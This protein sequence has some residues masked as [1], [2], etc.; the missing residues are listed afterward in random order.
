[1]NRRTFLRGIGL[2]GIVTVGLP[3]L[4]AMF[5]GNGAALKSTKK[6]VEPRFV[7]WFNGN[8]IP[9]KYW[10]PKETGEAFEFT[11]CLNPLA[12]FR[13]D[14]HVITGLDSAAARL[15]G[16]QRLDFSPDPL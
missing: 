4:E 12:P 14:I 3:P 6:A 7:F 11:P 1:M 8:G 2:G 10:I 15:P 9:E 16:T 13:K 5:D